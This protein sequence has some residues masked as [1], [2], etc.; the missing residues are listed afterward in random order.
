[1]KWV[2]LISLFFLFGC[3]VNLVTSV[4][5]RDA[6]LAL[7]YLTIAG[8]PA[9]KL[10]KNGKFD[11]RV[12]KDNLA[13][14]LEI[15]NKLSLG[16]QKPN[17]NKKSSRPSKEEER[18]FVERMLARELE[19]TLQNIPGVKTARVHIYSPDYDSLA[20]KNLEHERKKASTLISSDMPNQ[21][22]AE[23]VKAIISGATGIDT[24]KIIVTILDAP[25]LDLAVGPKSEE[26]KQTS[27][28]N[29][30]KILGFLVFTFIAAGV[31]YHAFRRAPKI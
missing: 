23:K 2:I 8:V 21:I 25:K 11:I 5:E 26:A 29:L 3:K 10:G 17:H 24:S 12:G 28:R 13:K 15:V 31:V 16:S 19:E 22:D 14:A 4:D 18:F 30:I 27:S 9:E 6:N 1:M 7:Y 20:L